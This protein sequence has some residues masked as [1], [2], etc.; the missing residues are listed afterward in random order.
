MPKMLRALITENTD[1]KKFCSAS[2]TTGWKSLRQSC[3]R[4]VV[5]GETTLE[6]VFR[7]TSV[8]NGI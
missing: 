1:M 4:K 2:N 8:S 7:V 3:S 6:D 5:L